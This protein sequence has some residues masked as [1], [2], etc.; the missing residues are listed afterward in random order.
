MEQFGFFKDRPPIL[1]I[2]SGISKRYLEDYPSW[3]G[4]LEEIAGRMGINGR[5]LKPYKS[6]ARDNNNFGY[7]PKLATELDQFLVRSLKEGTIVPEVLFNDDELNQYDNDVNP[8]KILISSRFRKYNFK[9]DR[10]LLSELD[11]FKK[12]INTIPSVI[13]TNYDSFL[14]ENVFN[15][16]KVY[17][18]ISD[19][20]FSDSEGIGEIFKI[21]GTALE[22][23]GIM[24]TEKDYV[25]YTKNSKIVTAKILSLLCDYPLL[26]LGYSLEDN[27]VKQ[28]ITDLM[29][30][31]NQEKL[32]QVEQN[33]IFIKHSK[34]EMDFK[35][36][37]NSFEL[38]DKRFSL[39]TIETDNF[40]QIFDDISKI[41]PSTNSSQIRRFRQLVKNLVI[42]SNPN[43]QQ[44]L[45][46]GAVDF[47]NKDLKDVVLIAADNTQVTRVLS[48]FTSCDN[49]VK[50]VLFNDISMDPS[51]VL[52]AFENK[53]LF[54]NTEYIPIYPY[55]SKSTIKILSPRL[56]EY[57][58]LKETQYPLE[59]VRKEGLQSGITCLSQLRQVKTYRIPMLIVYLLD[60]Q[61]ITF[62]QALNE[63]KCRY[64][65]LC[66]D[67]NAKS[68]MKMAVCYIMSKLYPVE[69]D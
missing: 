15:G 31:L 66:A 52:A 9:D 68:N 11:S 49:L 16:Y 21:H 3:E 61:I 38:G 33:I 30:S 59:R 28:I 57:F 6:S 25:D 62:D 40:K 1:L 69:F 23:D 36:S 42:T 64:N 24:I 51:T 27:D 10:N 54:K 39:Y 8:F 4:L 12:L 48:E 14:E 37:I 17:S 58:K 45:Y 55:Y 18:K 32:K 46:I 13:T 35:E 63:L 44:L 53:K 34:G 47:D 29:G 50:D 26:I 65:Q 60:K 43:Q 2:G 67:V 19:Y 41:V 20:Y 56:K 22:P 7:L 5:M